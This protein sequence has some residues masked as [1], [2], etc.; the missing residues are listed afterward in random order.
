MESREVF[1]SDKMIKHPTSNEKIEKFRRVFYEFF[2][3]SSVYML[4]LNL[5]KYQKGA[6]YCSYK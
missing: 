4:P 3:F 5:I 1:I 6:D 2:L